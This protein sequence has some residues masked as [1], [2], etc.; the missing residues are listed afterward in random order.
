MKRCAFD[1]DIRCGNCIDVMGAMEENS[2]HLIATD[3]PYGIDGMDAR[4]DDTKL[5]Q[6]ANKAGVVGGLPVGMKFDKKQGEDLQAFFEKVA[7]QSIKVL[8]HGG[9]FIAFSSPRLSH[10][11]AIALE[12]VGFEIRD[13][14]AW[15]YTRAQGKAFGMEHFVRKMNKSDKEKQSILEKLGGRKT[16]QLRPQFEPI[17]IAQKPTQG[18]LIENWLAWETGL[19]DLNNTTLNGH[20]PSTLLH[21][22]KPF[23]EK[24]N[25]H[26]TVKPVALMETL[27]RLFSKEGQVVLDPFMGSGTTLLATR[28]TNRRGIGIDIHQDYIS[29]AK[30]RLEEQGA[31]PAIGDVAS[32][33]R[34]SSMER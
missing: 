7:E 3:P 15:H 2:V 18:T 22:E 24:Y 30:K 20:T 19:I 26:L 27:I 17:I 14:Y 16:A 13:L 11:I 21:V 33:A 23:R 5:R 28:N 12:N 1:N 31:Q 25:R 6:K 10:R 9:F 8:R 34:T 29:L 4:W 32:S